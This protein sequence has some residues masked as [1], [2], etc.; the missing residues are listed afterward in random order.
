MADN[1]AACHFV[2]SASV[3]GRPLDLLDDPVI[4][5]GFSRFQFQAKPIHDHEERRARGIGHIFVYWAGRSLSRIHRGPAGGLHDVC[6]TST[7][8][9]EYREVRPDRHSHY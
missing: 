4:H 1:D 8:F 6:P 7:V 2:T 5:W 3:A 9:P